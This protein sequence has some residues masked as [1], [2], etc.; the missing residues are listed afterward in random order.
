MD[1]LSGQ[2]AG[3]S[4]PVTVSTKQQRIAEMARTA[5]KMA[6][7]LSHHMDLAWL[8]MAHRRT[9]K[10]GAAG[11]D[12]V[13][14]K[15]YEVDL[16]VNLQTLLGRAKS[17][18]Y[19]APSVR[20]VH[21][22]KGDGTQTRPLGI[23]TFED[24][25]L[26]RAVAMALEPVYEQDF[27]PCSFG[28]RPGRSAHQALE[29]LREG[30]R[31]MGGGFVIDLDIRSY[32]DTV[33]HGQLQR[34]LAQRVRDGVIRRLV[35][36]WLN[37]GV[38]E[39]GRTTYPGRGVPQGGVISP[40]LSNLYLHDVLDVWFHEQVIPCMRGRAFLVRFA[41]DAV[42]AFS[43]KTD[44]E[45]VFRTLPKRFAKYG[46]TLHPDKTRLVDFRPA[47]RGSSFEFLGFCHYWKKSRKKRP[48]LARKT[49]RVRMTRSLRAMNLWLKRVRHMPIT[50]QHKMLSL[51]LRGHYQYFGITGNSRA[52]S[53][54]LLAAK[55]LW[56]K[57]LARRSN[58]APKS[59]QW[60]VALLGRLPLPPP[61]AVHS[62]LRHAANP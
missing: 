9:R 48:T 3:V 22:P 11:V 36:K 19:R 25:I 7:N 56:R 15:D 59:W 17:G 10:D 21:I 44:A 37:A 35:G 38:L 1:L 43:N 27:L 41:D 28:F 5:P 24:K 14:H 42:L 12:G 30:L 61:I 6:M 2:T 40:L 57:W 33:D 60:F 52:L 50:Y 34:L 20:R 47:Y 46:L 45:R 55:R 49:S 32:F 8:A 58:K 23:P 62:V 51:K 13:T 18:A 29:T 39:E 54:Y 26:Q 53:A 4:K 31:A 16:T